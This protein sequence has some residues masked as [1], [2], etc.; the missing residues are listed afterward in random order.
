MS[1]DHVATSTLCALRVPLP[2]LAD[3]LFEARCFK[4]FQDGFNSS[5]YPSRKFS[6]IWVYIFLVLH[7]FMTC[8][9]VQWGSWGAWCHHVG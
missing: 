2:I 6:F 5:Y 3:E 1:L 7:Y 9:F 8:N 4:L